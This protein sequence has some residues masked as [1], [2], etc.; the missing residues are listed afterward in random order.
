MDRTVYKYII[1]TDSGRLLWLLANWD[2]THSGHNLMFVLT[3]KQRQTPDFNVMNYEYICSRI[4]LGDNTIGLIQ[5]QQNALLIEIII[6]KKNYLY[7]LNL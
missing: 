4:V 2:D 7:E 3:Q 1:V 6:D 5:E